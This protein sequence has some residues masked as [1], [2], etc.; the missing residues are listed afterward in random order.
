MKKYLIFRTDRIGDFLLTAI[1]IK[2]IKRNDPNSHI[3][4]VA[5]KQNFDYIKSFNDVNEVFLFKNSFF[6]KLKFIFNIRKY[7]YDYVIVHDEKNRSSLISTFCNYKSRIIINKS[8]NLTYINKIKNILLDLNYNFLEQD[9]N[10]LQSRKIK[11]I[12]INSE[13][14]LFHFDEKWIFNDYIDEF[15]NIE[16]SEYQ[17]EKFI[18]SIYLKSNKRLIITTGIISP[19]KLNN[20]VNK[21]NNSNITIFSNLNFIDL[22]NIV[23]KSNLIISCHGAIS[24]LASAR[25]IKQIDIIEYKK[26]EFYKLWTDHFRNH[27]FIY[28]KNFNELASDI[29]ELI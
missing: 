25:N 24:H 26:L 20:V 13:F 29:I 4:I 3:S 7:F 19:K 10:I 22:E 9:L 11:N 28:R 2:S 16:P 18:N 12:N 15:T 23:S 5:S 8:T 1:L 21:I 17:L 6:F 14:I 27:N